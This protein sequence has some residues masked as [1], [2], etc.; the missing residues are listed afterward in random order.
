MRASIGPFGRR[1]L[2]MR[3]T[4]LAM[5]GLVAV[6]AACGQQD[7]T[8]DPPTASE[9][10]EIDAA[11]QPAG[12]TA[13]EATTEQS[14]ITQ[15]ATI[16]FPDIS[17]LQACTSVDHEAVASPPITSSG[18]A[19]R[20]NLHRRQHTATRLNDGRILAIGGEAAAGMTASAE[21][22]D[23]L[24]EEWTPAGTMSTPRVGHTATVLS[25]GRVLVVGGHSSIV[26][27]PLSSAEI[28]DPGD[29]TWTPAG[30]LHSARRSH[31]AVLLRDG[32][33]LV[34]GGQ[35]KVFAGALDQA[36]IFDPASR[37]WT[38]TQPM[39]SSRWGHTA[40]LLSDG[41]VL[42]VG[43][44]SD[45]PAFIRSAETYEPV[46]GEWSDAGALQ[47]ARA[48]ST[49]VQLDE[50]NVLVASGSPE[51]TTTE[52]GDLS[53]GVWTSG[54][55][56]TAIGTLSSAVV[57][58]DGRLL[59]GGGYGDDDPSLSTVGV[60]DPAAGDWSPISDMRYSRADH[61]YNLLSNG[62]VLVTGGRSLSGPHR[63]SEIYDPETDTWR[64]A[65][66]GLEQ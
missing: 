44:K 27:C 15:P 21:V 19:G 9:L 34:T 57:L 53:T 38:A 25:D 5:I 4:I 33:V 49:V 60:F 2:K 37:S 32:R 12:D 40:I 20:M 1:K 61:T 16:V 22:F 35:S 23:T 24:T 6:A 46:S 56:L 41:M 18:I 10:T 29:G 36:E 48:W 51:Y 58:S 28:Y 17:E 42:V 65:G 39:L 64:L 26:E 59:L 14:A 45:E 63:D 50:T 8:D 62:T 43:G 31:A 52:T 54:P 11:T 66:T 30:S 55:R 13:G 7:V 3:W 47:H